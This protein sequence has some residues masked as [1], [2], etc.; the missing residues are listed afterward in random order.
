MS[1]N[2]KKSHTNDGKLKNVIECSNW[3]SL[4]PCPSCRSRREL[5]NGGIER[6]VRPNLTPVRSV[7]SF[8][9]R[10][11]RFRFQRFRFQRFLGASV[12]RFQARNRLVN[13]DPV[14]FLS[15]MYQIN[16]LNISCSICYIFRCRIRMR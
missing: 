16:W 1:K 5:S 3:L 15:F 2:E 13:R 4:K 6:S 9:F 14:R 7:T 8:G 12:P 10:F 11:H